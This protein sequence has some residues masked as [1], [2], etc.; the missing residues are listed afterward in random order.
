[1]D[2]RDPGWTTVRCVVPSYYRHGLRS[3]GF[4]ARKAECAE[5]SAGRRFAED[6]GDAFA[7]FARCFIGEGDGWDLV[8]KGTFGQLDVG[9]A[10]GQHAG[11]SAILV[12]LTEDGSLVLADLSVRI[13]PGPEN[14]WVKPCFAV[15]PLVAGTSQSRI[16]ATQSRVTAEQ[17]ARIRR[18]VA[19][20]IGLE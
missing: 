2:R 10:G 17:L 11:Q 8:A 19:E 13:D 7:Y 1:M 20:A 6:G 14:G 16:R 4:R 18:Q 9:E 3:R 12:P 5:P 15:S